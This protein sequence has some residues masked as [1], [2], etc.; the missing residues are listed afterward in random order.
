MR[1]FIMA[2]AGL[3]TL[4]ACSAEDRATLSFAAMSHDEHLSCA[5]QISAF[6]RL[7]VSGK[8]E[9]LPAGTGDR[10]IGMMTHL[11]AFAVPQD[12]REPDAF[13]ALNEL[14]DTLLAE[15]EPDE[16]RSKA[17]DCIDLAQQAL[18]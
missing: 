14:R 9:T 18:G 3:A 1:K 4:A 6:D 15:R 7:L 2:V 11:N 16:I 13:A 5:A 12:I 17:I 10:R 8:A